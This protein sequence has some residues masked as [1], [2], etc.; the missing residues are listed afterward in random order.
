MTDKM[1]N[2][3][4]RS[5][6]A[7]LALLLGMLAFIG[8][9]AH[10]WLGPINPPPKL[11]DSIAEEAV[12]IRDKV[13]AKL[14]GEDVPAETYKLDWDADRIAMAAIASFGALAILLAVVGFV[15]HEPLRM[16]GSA[17]A[18]GAIALALQYLIVAIGAIIFAII[19]AAVLGGLSF[20]N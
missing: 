7:L 9:V 11:E 14:K 18:L 17:A 8:S 6:A 10:F 2:N 1:K 12:K 16:V 5:F 19:I 3:K 13:V 15:R 4:E 20:L